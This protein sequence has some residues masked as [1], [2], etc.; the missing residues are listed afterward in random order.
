M[1]S[2]APSRA[3][4]IETERL[5]LRE[6]G[7]ADLDQAVAFWARPDVY[8]HIDG[9]PRAREDVWR[10]LLANAGAWSLL[11]FGSWLVETRD[12]EKFIGT[13]G[14][15][16]AER[17]MAPGFLAGEVEMGW[18]LS[19]DAQGKGYALEAL[20]AT[21]RW[22]D[23]VMPGRTLVCII[24]PGNGPSLKLA[25]KTGFRERGPAM[26]RDEYVIQFERTTPA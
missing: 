4:T 3:P 6:Q 15:L 5:R 26:Y 12:E 25:R 16:Q 17:E 18:G 7:V 8:R 19:P 22:A 21:L 20:S 10:R 14:F 9:K 1:T 24:N 23:A 11:G 2:S 13:F